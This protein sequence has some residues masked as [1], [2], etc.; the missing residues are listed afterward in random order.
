MFEVALDIPPII[1]H[2]GCILGN[3][4][5]NSPKL[6]IKSASYVPVC[7]LNTPALAAMVGSVTGVIPHS[8]PII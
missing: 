6:W 1:V 7:R 4:V 8:C 5:T 2:D 3:W